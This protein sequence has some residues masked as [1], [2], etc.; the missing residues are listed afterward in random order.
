MEILKCLALTVATS[1]LACAAVAADSVAIPGGQLDTTISGLDVFIGEPKPADPGTTPA[2]LQAKKYVDTL[3]AG[4]YAEMASLFAD[5]ATFLDPLR[6]NVNGHLNIAD[7]YQNTIGP[8]HLTVVGVAFVGQGSDCILELAVKEKVN[9]QERYVM[10]GL[11][12]FTLNAAGKFSR[13]VVFTRPPPAGAVLPPGATLPTS[14]SERR[15]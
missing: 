3:R 8:M 15:N 2:C 7:F 1:G 10:G 4:K 11:D 5:H 6:K 13:M 12:H 9:G 14:A